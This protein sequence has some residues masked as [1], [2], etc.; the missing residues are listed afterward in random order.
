M[1]PDIFIFQISKEDDYWKWAKSQFIESV[2]A[3]KWYNGKAESVE[4]FIGN[5]RSLLVGMPRIRQ[6]RV[7]PGKNVES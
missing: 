5:K 6:L 7:K 2:F 3:G 1:L 4:A